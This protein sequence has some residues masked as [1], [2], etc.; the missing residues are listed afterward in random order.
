MCMGNICRSPTAHGVFQSFVTSQSLQESIG[1]DSAGTYAYH[2]GEKPDPRAR[3]AA[4]KRGYD[5]NNIRARKVTPSDFLDFDYILAM[6][7]ENKRDLLDICE[8]KHKHKIKL[9][10]DFSKK[11][12]VRE[13]PDPYYGGTNGFETVLDLIEGAS[14]EL[15]E[16]IKIKHSLESQQ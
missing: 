6:D 16:Y 4:S 12:K 11:P 14:Q 7:N 15:L 2:A 10:L 1:I 9:L 13:V 3:A 8:H 5:L